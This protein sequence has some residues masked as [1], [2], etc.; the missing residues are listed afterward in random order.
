MF[1]NKLNCSHNHHELKTKYQGDDVFL[2]IKLRDNAGAYVS[3]LSFSDIVVYVYTD[4][5][6]TVKGSVVPK[7]GYISMNL[8][9]NYTYELV[10]DSSFTSKMNPGIV[11]M[12]INFIKNSI[13]TDI[14]DSN[15]NSIAIKNGIFYLSESIIKVE[16]NP[17]V[18]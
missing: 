6:T 2:N 3:L 13:N 7:V 12:E 10:L 15:Y 8:I 14:L 17:V 1:G 9:D 18:I 5:Y 4:E 11:T 16:S